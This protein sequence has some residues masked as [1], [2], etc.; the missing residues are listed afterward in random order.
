MVNRRDG[1]S[2]HVVLMV[3]FIAVVLAGALPCFGD[4]DLRELTTE[5][6]AAVTGGL[7][8]WVCRE[9]SH[10][11]FPDHCKGD[12]A[13]ASRTFYGVCN[14]HDAYSRKRFY[15]SPH[16][17]CKWAWYKLENEP[18]CPEQP[19]RWKCRRIVYYFS[20]NCAAG[21]VM[22]VDFENDFNSC[23]PEP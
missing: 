8:A 15:R 6:M 19:Y 2:S 17:Q 4:D 14:G 23:K 7:G 22:C 16:M 3:V 12:Q 9:P 13:C 10:V 21:T 20:D 18:P 5:E 1:V 11:T